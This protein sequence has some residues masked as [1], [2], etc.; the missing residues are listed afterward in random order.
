MQR[1]LLQ[2]LLCPDSNK[3]NDYLHVRERSG[4]YGFQ[5]YLEKVKIVEHRTTLTR[6]RTGCKCFALDTGRFENMPRKNRICPLCK[7][8]VEDAKHFLF[9][10]KYKMKSRT[11]LEHILATISNKRYKYADANGKLNILLNMKLED[12]DLTQRISKAIYQLYKE[13]LEWEKHKNKQWPFSP[14]IFGE[15]FLN[16]I[17][18]CS[19]IFSLVAAAFFFYF[20]YVF[21]MNPSW[22]NFHYVKPDLLI[23]LFEIEIELITSL[24]SVGVTTWRLSAKSL[25]CN[26]ALQAVI[27][28]FLKPWTLKK[29]LRPYFVWQ[30]LVCFFGTPK[31]HKSQNKHRFIASSF[32]CTTKPLSVLHTWIFSNIE[33]KFSNLSSVMY[34]CTSVNKTWIVKNSSELLQKMNSFIIQR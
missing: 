6:L 29:S 28:T 30:V 34:S 25:V 24:W 3:L 8:R 27:I 22:V 33:G 19:S 11:N 21:V 20:V 1:Y 14:S 16:M 15:C 32:D 7:S 23:K 4:D 5:S 10:C 17:I 13:R 26:Q 18:S 9:K 2:N 12:V 31:L